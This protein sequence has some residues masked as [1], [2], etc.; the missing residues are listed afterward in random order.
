[1]S[2]RASG[3]SDASAVIKELTKS[4]GRASKVRKAINSATR[5]Y[6]HSAI[7]CNSS[8]I[9]FRGSGFIAKTIQYNKK[10]QPKTL[11]VLFI[12]TE[13]ESEMLFRSR[14]IQCAEI[15]L[16]DLLDRTTFR[17]CKY[18]DEIFLTLSDDDKQH[19]ELISAMAVGNNNP[20]KDS[21]TMPTV[22][23]S[24]SKAPPRPQDHS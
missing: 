17:L 15:N 13:S 10:C 21:K 3:K 16:Q 12:V 5:R 8:L 19:F 23:P 24:S 20:N 11:S 18:L 4:P 1:M 6:S 7:E 14:F 22:T 9:N 2:L